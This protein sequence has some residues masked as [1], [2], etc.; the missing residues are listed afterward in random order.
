MNLWYIHLVVSNSNW[1]ITAISHLASLFYN[2]TAYLKFGDSREGYEIKMSAILIKAFVCLIYLMMNYFIDYQKK[3]NFCITNTLL[4]V[5][6]IFISN[7]M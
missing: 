5:I 2:V 1:M 3:I 7:F 6:Q 4:H